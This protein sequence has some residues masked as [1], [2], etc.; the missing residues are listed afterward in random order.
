MTKKILI[1]RWKAYNYL[2]IKHHFILR[3][4]EVDEIYQH[5]ESY[6]VEDSFAE[7]IRD[8]IKSSSYEFVFSVNY[9]GVISNV[10]KEIGIP[11]ISWSCD[12]P[13]ISMYHDSVFNEVNKI[14]L[15][16]YISYNEFKE[17]GVKNVNYLPLCVDVNRL[18]ALISKADDLDN[19][20]NNISFVGSLYERNNYDTVETELGD[21]LRGY[22]DCYIELQA[23]MP[24]MP[25]IDAAL[26]VDILAQIQE[27]FK[28]NKSEGSF[29]DLGLIFQ[30]TTLGFKVAKKQRID[31]LNML[32]KKYKVSIYS[33]SDTEV[34]PLTEYKGG[35]DYWLEMPKAF[36]MSK[37]NLNFTIPNI[38]SGIPLRVWDIMG[39]GGFLIT[40]KQPE[41]AL[42]FKEDEEI[43]TFSSYGELLEKTDYYI[44]NDKARRSVVE[45]ALKKV[46]K[47]HTYDVRLEEMFSSLK[48]EL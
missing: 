20:K 10:C 48:G 44:I 5:L 32:S 1:Y 18:R 45:N 30:T 4:Y 6:D 37:I 42:F 21:Y 25:L 8:K 7:K 46:E 43:V 34:L 16:D 31:A 3:G 27:R 11:Y 28:L 33:N 29:S 9:F 36:N 17:M 38:K 13:L 41:M 15:F 2:D 24:G 39:S 14:F 40:N 22:L 12:S 35:L 23:N 47:F 26:S 19:Y